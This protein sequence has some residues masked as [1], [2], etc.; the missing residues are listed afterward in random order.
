[1]EKKKT[2]KWVKCWK[3][4]KETQICVNAM[5]FLCIIMLFLSSFLFLFSWSMNFV[6]FNQNS[7]GIL[8]KNK[9]LRLFCLSLFL[10]L[11]GP[12]VQR[13]R[14]RSQSSPSPVPRIEYS[15]VLHTRANGLSLNFLV[16]SKSKCFRR[17]KKK[18]KKLRFDFFVYERHDPWHGTKYH[19]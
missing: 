14:D 3:R 1:M 12:T 9:V 17:S 13:L 6:L 2:I 16:N 15:L 19:Q 18:G 11:S 10:R 7:K 5:W 8:M 4:H